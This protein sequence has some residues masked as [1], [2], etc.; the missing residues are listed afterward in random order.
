MPQYHALTSFVGFQSH[1]VVRWKRHHKSWIE[2]WIEY[3]GR[4][5]RCGGCGRKCVRRHDQVSTRIRD[6][7]ISKHKV[8]L[9]LPRFRVRCPC[10]GVHQARSVIARGGARCTRRFELHLFIL[11]DFMPVKAVAEQERVDWKTVKDVEIRYIVG[12]LRKRDLDGVT[13]IGI[14]EVSEKKGHRYL[15]LVTDIGKRRVLW[16]GRGNDSAVLKRFF[17]WFGLQRTRRLKLVVIDMHDPYLFALRKSCRARIIFDRFHVVKPLHLAIDKI[18]IRQYKELPPEGRRYVKNSRFLLLRRR[19]GLSA[20][21]RV[22]LKELLAV[23]ETLNTAYVL[24]EDLRG[25]F[26]IR[27]SKTARAEF[28]AWKQ[29]ARE[30]DI[31]EILEYVKLLDRRRFGILNFFKHRKTNGLSEGFNNVV[32]T[33]KKWPM[34]FMIGVISIS[35]YSVSVEN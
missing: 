3:Q 14:D 8:F 28:R 10:C 29:R 2:L 4:T 35:R 19:E 1:K 20:K 25:I 9:W 17:L 34:D 7:D 21:G 30:S 33:I 23:N 18:R 5:L 6:L 11:T 12:L 13:E 31:P 15:T 32:K 24:K 27:D 22:R 16:V 26:D